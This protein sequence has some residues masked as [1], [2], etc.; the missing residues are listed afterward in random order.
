MIRPRLGHTA[1][2]MGKSV[3]TLKRGLR[4]GHR[5][6]YREQNCKYGFELLNGFESYFGL[7][8]SLKRFMIEIQTFLKL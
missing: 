8:S 7:S 5:V 3:K 1:V 4:K 2:K 6:R